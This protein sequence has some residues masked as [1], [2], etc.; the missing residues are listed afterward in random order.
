MAAQQLHPRQ[1]VERSYE[2]GDTSAPAAARRVVRDL[3]PLGRDSRR[4]LTIIV[5]E[6]VANAVRHAPRVAG[7]HVRLVIDAARD[8]IRVDVHDP[9]VGF[10]PTPAASGEGGLGLAIVGR[11]AHD[12][13]IDA[14]GHT[15]V[16]CVLRPT[17]ATSA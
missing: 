7:G 17:A 9:G 3:Q 4:D 13:G 15:T 11:M 12:W 14:A 6:L 2:Q 8:E 1:H 10:D 16:W 5:S